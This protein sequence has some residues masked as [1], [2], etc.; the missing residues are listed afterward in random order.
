VLCKVL[1]IFEEFWGNTKIFHIFIFQAFKKII[2]A[3]IQTKK[4]T[5]CI[6]IHRDFHEVSGS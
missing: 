4:V 3:K 5:L 2:F 6:L 1:G